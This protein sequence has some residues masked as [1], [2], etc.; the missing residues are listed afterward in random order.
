MNKKELYLEPKII[1][2]GLEDL[3]SCIKLDLK[4]FNGIWNAKQWKNELSD[5]ERICL[6]AINGKQLIALGCAWLV[7]DELNITLI[8]VDPFYQRMGIGTLIVSSLLKAGQDAGANQIFIEARKTNI[9]AKLFYK[10]LDFTEV[11]YRP[12]LYKDG[13]EGRLFH[14]NCKIDT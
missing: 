7:L 14:R 1:K 4:T 13:E 9:S 11:G 6:G 10:N 2:L 8:G 12:N 5:Q 3:N